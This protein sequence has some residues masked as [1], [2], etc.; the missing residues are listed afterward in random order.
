MDIQTNKIRREIVAITFFICFGLV[1]WLIVRSG[2]I[3]LAAACMFYA[4]YLQ[5]REG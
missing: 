5:Y 1:V 2:W 3:G 4:G